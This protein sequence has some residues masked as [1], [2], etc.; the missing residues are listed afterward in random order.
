[1]PYFYV[2]CNISDQEVDSL[3]GTASEL[4]AMKLELTCETLKKDHDS[5]KKKFTTLESQMKKAESERKQDKKNLVAELADM[6][7]QMNDSQRQITKLS[8]IFNGPAI[9]GL[10]ATHSP[11][12]L[13]YPMIQLIE[14]RYYVRFRDFEICDVHPLPRPRGRNGKEYGEASVIVKFNSWHDRSAYT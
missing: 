1:M 10:L 11:N 3:L 9:D 7:R 4:G 13:F 6:R 12:D 8:L 5:L 14:R 2:I